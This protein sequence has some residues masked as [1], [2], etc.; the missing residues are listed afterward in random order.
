VANVRKEGGTFSIICK[1]QWLFWV[2]L[3]LCPLTTVWYNNSEQF[4]WNGKETPT[5]RK[6]IEVNPIKSL[7]AKFVEG[8]DLKTEG[9]SKK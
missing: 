3:L 8:N 9:L 1:S 2:V 6:D 5:S 7:K 4:A